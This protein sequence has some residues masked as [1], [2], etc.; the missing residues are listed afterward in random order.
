MAFT[1]VKGLYYMYKAGDHVFYPKGGVF[2][3]EKE[4]DKK[5]GGNK[6]TF[7]DLLSS[8]GKTKISIPTANVERVGVRK[9]VSP[10]ELNQHIA[11]WV[12][13]IKVS[14]LHHKN[15][16]SRFETLRQTGN[17]EDMSIVVVTIHY[18]VHISKAT[19]EEKRMYDQIRKRLINEVQIVRDCTESRAEA[20]LLDA[21]DQAVLRKPPKE[22]EEEET[23]AE[24]QQA[25]A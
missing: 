22:E 2:V 8:D 9:L 20:I 5:I 16:K 11:S 23:E 15:R 6:I 4:C 12:P 18:L 1:L 3:I 10:R 19:F 21:L 17:F 14:K 13:D 25:T 7:Y 24:E